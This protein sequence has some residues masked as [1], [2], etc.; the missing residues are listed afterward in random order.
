MRELKLLLKKDFYLS[1]TGPLKKAKAKNKGLRGYLQLVLIGILFIY[2][3]FLYFALFNGLILPGIKRG[4]SQ[5]I[6]SFFTIAISLVAII[7]TVAEIISKIYFSNDVKILLS[8]PIRRNNIFM[9][10][11]LVS[12]ID[13]CGLCLLGLIPIFYGTLKYTDINFFTM[14]G[15][16]FLNFSNICLTLSLISFLIVVFM[17]IFGGRGNLKNFLQIIGFLLIMFLSFG[18]QIIVNRFFASGANIDYEKL[19]NLIKFIFPQIFILSKI[20]TLNNFLSLILG[21]G[22]LIFDFCIFYFLSFPLSKIMAEGVLKNEVTANK[23]AHRT[24]NKKTSASFAIGKKDLLNIVKT[25]VYFFN[26]GITGIIFPILLLINLINL[27]SKKGNFESLR[28]FLSNLN[29]YGLKTFDIF[30]IFAFLFFLYSIFLQPSTL[31]SF[32]REG[33][34]IYLMQ[35][36]PISYEDQIRGRLFASLF[37]QMLNILPMIFLIGYISGFKLINIFAMFLG[38]IAGSFFSSIFGLLFGIIY[39]KFDWDNPQQAVKKNFSIFIFNLIS[40]GIIGLLIIFIY[41]LFK[42]FNLDF[43]IIKILILILILCFLILSIFL[44]KRSKDLLREKLPSYN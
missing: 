9:S 44:K 1:F 12:M 43:N 13:I 11:I 14:F 29:T 22:A 37:F 25:P 42:K 28:N 2:F 17:K 3:L 40:L 16:L 26:I 10:K 5:N 39:P 32:T 34:S 35:T 19:L 18:P 15:I 33:K 36:L 30:I 8:L 24:K 4:Q 23:K 6:L 41:L 20:Y 7:F 27:S 31:T 21:I 38:G